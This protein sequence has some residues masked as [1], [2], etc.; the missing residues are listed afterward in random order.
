MEKV[1]CFQ[2]ASEQNI[3]DCY[4]LS[5]NCVKR[6]Q[7]ENDTILSNQ[8]V[9]QVWEINVSQRGLQEALFSCTSIADHSSMD[10]D[11]GNQWTQL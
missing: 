11:I 2:N 10:C 8:M 4:L 1:S 6:K 7:V 3:F 9:G 5:K